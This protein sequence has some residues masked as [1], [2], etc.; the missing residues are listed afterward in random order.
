[1]TACPDKRPHCDGEETPNWRSGLVVSR[2]A[3][4]VVISLEECLSDQS[5]DVGA[6]SGVEHAAAVASSGDQ[7]GEAQL[8]EVLARGGSRDSSEAGQ[9]GDVQLAVCQRPQD[10]Q[11]TWLGSHAERSDRHV[12]LAIRWH[13]SIGRIGRRQLWG[14]SPSSWC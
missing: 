8:G 9:G 4:D 11:P 1:M 14:G 5:S 2:G 13:L 12:N 3:A 10:A 7:P 6:P